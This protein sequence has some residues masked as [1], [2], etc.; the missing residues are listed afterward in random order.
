M[1]FAAASHRPIVGAVATQ[2]VSD[3]V[4]FLRKTY[5][6]LGV[7]LLAFA[8]IAGGMIRFTPEASIK[9]S[10]WALT[11]QW[12]W[13]LV[14]GG[15][16]LVGYLAQRL[17][18]SETSRGLQYLGLAIFVVAEAFLLQPLIWILM[19]RFGGAGAMAI[20]SQA[21]VITLTIFLGLTLT[22]FLTR[23]DFSFLHGILT[24][25][26]FAVLGVIIA[27]IAFGFSLGAFFCGAVILLM[28]GYILFQ[29][30]AI[31]KDFP[32]TAYVAAALMLFSTIATLFWYVLQFL[33]S[34]RND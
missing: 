18:M 2:G 30:S 6:H 3:R 25:G 31:M 26:S 10:R 9:F 33:A 7:A 4:A 8:A 1:A 34:L 19:L 14:I 27:A 17:A 15:F 16:M 21:T 23:K 22:V 29:T 12:S 11:G 5:A 20:V 13:L 24:V 28:S 32:P